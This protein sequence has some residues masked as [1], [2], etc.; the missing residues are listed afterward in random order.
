MILGRWKQIREMAQAH[1]RTGSLVG[2]GLIVVALVWVLFFRDGTS[3]AELLW[4]LKAQRRAYHGAPPVI[5]H[6]VLGGRCSRCHGNQAVKVP[7]VGVAPPNP[8]LRTLGMSEESNCRQCHVFRKTEEVLVASL[9]QGSSRAPVPGSR[10][11]PTGPPVI[12]HAI[13]MRED[14]L[15]CHWGEATVPEIRCNHPERRNC[16][17]CHALG[18]VAGRRQ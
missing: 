7:G 15:K 3:S 4:Q 6:P 11:Y 2:G 14:C 10:M 16:R 8:H 17:Q 12:P 9:F 13:F 18:L 1:W 5:P